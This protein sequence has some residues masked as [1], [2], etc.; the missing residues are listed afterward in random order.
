MSAQ[1]LRAAALRD[2]LETDGGDVEVKRWQEGK[3]LGEARDGS[4]I[5]EITQALPGQP[6]HSLSK[7]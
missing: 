2:D 3:D 4:A 5:D 7:F 6:P 1:S